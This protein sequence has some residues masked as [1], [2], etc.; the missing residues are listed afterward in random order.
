MVQIWNKS[1]ISLIPDCPELAGIITVYNF[2]QHLVRPRRDGTTQSPEMV[3]E[4]TA[5]SR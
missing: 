3:A 4:Y 1:Y 5:P 2:L